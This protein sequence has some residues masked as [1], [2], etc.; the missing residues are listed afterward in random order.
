MREET[1]MLT[2]GIL[3]DYGVNVKEGLNRC[4]NNEAFYLKM[5]KMALS[6]DYFNTLGE[7]LAKNDLAAAFEA[8][9]ALKGVV[10]NLSITSLYEPLS[11]LTEKLRA[12]EDT[13]YT[14]LYTPIKETHARLLALCQD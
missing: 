8:A 12:H 1:N 6:N 11:V 14:A 7:T 5:V 10:G 3:E 2:L 9:H 13:D 4:M